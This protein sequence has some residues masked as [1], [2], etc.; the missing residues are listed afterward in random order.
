MPAHVVEMTSEV[1]VTEGE[2]P[3]T[4]AQVER[5][6]ELVLVRLADR[7][8]ERERS[9]EATRLRRQSSPPFEAGGW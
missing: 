7:E 9:R 1:T 5:L 6:V 2:L 3:L 8:R 4:P